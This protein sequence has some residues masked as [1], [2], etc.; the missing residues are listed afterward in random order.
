MAAIP[1][2]LILD[3]SGSMTE[4]DAP[5]PRIDAAKDAAVALIDA[6]PGDARVALLTY[7]TGTGS[8]EADKPIGCNDVKTLIPLGPLDRTAATAQISAIAPS[9]YTPISLALHRAADQLPADDSAQAIV[10]LS[11]GEDR[12]DMPPCETA[13]SLKQ[14]RPGLTISTVGFKTDGPAS[15]ELACIAR[16][17]DGMFVQADNAAQL[18]ARLVAVQ[19]VDHAKTSLTG[20]GIDGIRLGQPID[21]IR[22]NRPDFPAV[23][24]SGEFTV[25]YID[26]DFGFAD[27]VLDS[28]APNSGGRTIDGVTVGSELSRMTEL[29]GEPAVVDAADRRV[30]Y[31]ADPGNRGSRIGYRID[32]DD[33]AERGGTVHGT[34]GRIVLCRC[35]PMELG[36]WADPVV[37]VTPNS[38]GAATLSMNNDEVAAAAGVRLI[39]PCTQCDG[40]PYADLPDGYP[41][42]IASISGDGGQ[43]RVWLP[44]RRPAP[45]QVVQTAEGFPLG[46]SVDELRRIYGDRIRPYYALGMYS[47]NG[48]ALDSADGHLVFNAIADHGT[49]LGPT[50]HEFWV[51]DKLYG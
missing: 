22:A 33:F 21:E 1:T 4:T 26:C 39:R 20:D 27:G 13:A 35:L 49:E 2:A 7:G 24:T 9:G 18:A 17:T 30:F 51:T 5:G 44:D 29:Y 25:T 45:M 43:F 3:A 47:V 28:I 8:A 40:F 11:D 46:G 34:V 14:S 50:V 32:V 6:L 31:R 19:N 15:D 48:Y 12:C 16:V 41:S 10:L 23:S 36:G 38:V 37:I 42:Y